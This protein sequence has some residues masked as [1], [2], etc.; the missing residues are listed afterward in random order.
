LGAIES[1]YL[2]THFY[3]ARVSYLVFPVSFTDSFQLCDFGLPAH[4][5]SNSP[6]RRPLIAVRDILNHKVC[7]LSSSCELYPQFT[8]SCNSVATCVVRVITFEL[9]GDVTSILHNSRLFAGAVCTIRC[10]VTHGHHEFHAQNFV[11]LESFYLLKSTNLS[12]L[13]FLPP[14][15]VIVDCWF[16]S[17][18]EKKKKDLVQ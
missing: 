15:T 18:R 16:H 8:Q 5:C 9:T 10:D 1:L 3:H 7:V 6:P 4:S 11:L 13:R 2:K 14:V 12:L 17:R